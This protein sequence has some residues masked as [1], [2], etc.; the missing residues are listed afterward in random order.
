MTKLTESDITT[1]LRKHRLVDIRFRHEI[2]EF[3]TYDLAL[4]TKLNSVM[5]AVVLV[6]AIVLVFLANHFKEMN[7]FAGWYFVCLNFFLSA[8]N[9]GMF[10]LL[11]KSM[12]GDI[13]GDCK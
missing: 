13:K 11:G 3:T 1:F 7:N 12:K 8:S 4:M 6:I 9:V 2:G 10:Y 5:C